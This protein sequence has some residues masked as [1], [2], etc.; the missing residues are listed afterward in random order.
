VST[1]HPSFVVARRPVQCG[2]EGQIVGN[3]CGHGDSYEAVIS[4]ADVN[5]N[6]W[7]PEPGIINSDVTQAHVEVS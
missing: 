7:Q 6:V 1:T 5:A 2:D 4:A 3:G